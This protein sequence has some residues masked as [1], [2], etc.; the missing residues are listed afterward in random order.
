MIDCQTHCAI[1]DHHRQLGLN[2]AQIAEALGLDRR[3]VAKWLAEPRFRARTASSRASKVDRHR[4]SIRRWLEVHRYSAQQVLQRLRE[5]TGY[6]C[7]IDIVKD[8][9]FRGRMKP[10]VTRRT[11]FRNASGYC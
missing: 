9:L 11:F 5:E 6:I 8:R 10:A 4:P 3:R 2:G 7:G 1:H